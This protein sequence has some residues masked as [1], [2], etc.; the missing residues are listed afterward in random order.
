MNRTL[1]EATAK[2]Y[3]NESH[4]QLKNHPYTFMQAYKFAKRLK[5][6]RGLTPYEF[7][8]K[9]WQIEPER[10]KVNPFHHSLG[11]NNYPVSLQFSFKKFL[12]TY[13]I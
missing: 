10:F 5:T 11:L 3:Y 7:I 1:K 9:C 12:S 2:R 6:Q 4:T 8:I 13:F